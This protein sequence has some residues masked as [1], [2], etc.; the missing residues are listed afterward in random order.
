LAILLL[1][2]SLFT[3]NDV[4]VN[5]PGSFIAL[6]AVIFVAVSQSKTGTVQKT[7]GINGPSAQHGTAFHQFVLALVSAFIVETHGPGN[8][9]AHNFVKNET[10]IIILTGFVSVSVNVCAFGLI[11]KTSAVTYQ[12]VGH[13][14]TILIFIFGLLMFPPKQNE[15]VGQFRKK[16]AGLVVSMSGM[17]FYTYLELKA[18][19]KATVKAQG[20]VQPL[21]TEMKAEEEEE[22]EG[23]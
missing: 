19:E 17:I 6:L 5:L 15:T 11:G 3:V 21:L 4:Q 9:F 18:K 23:H 13:C 22:D 16:I 1:G 2:I 12:V 20:E 14:K 7:Y 10:I 8:V